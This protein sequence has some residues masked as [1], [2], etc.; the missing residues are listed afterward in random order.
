[1]LQDSDSVQQNVQTGP[2][3]VSDDDSV[4]SINQDEEELDVS[5]P[6][7]GSSDVG[8]QP[9]LW[10]IRLIDI[11]AVRNSTGASG[12]TGGSSSGRAGRSSMGNVMYLEPPSLRRSTTAAAIAT[13][14]RPNSMA[15]TASGLARAF[16]LV[17]RQIADLLTM[18]MDHSALASTLPRNL[19]I[20]Q[21]E[22]AQL[23]TFFEFR[24]KPVWDWL[25]NV[26]DSTEVQLRFG[27]ALSSTSAAS[28][29]QSNHSTFF[30][31]SPLAGTLTATTTRTPGSASATAS[32]LAGSSSA[33]TGSR[34]SRAQTGTS[35]GG[36]GGEGGIGG[37]GDRANDSNDPPTGRREFLNYCLSLMRAHNGEHS[38]TLPV[39]DV[40]SLKHI[41][42]IFDALIYYIRSRNDTNP[43][44]EESESEEFISDIL[45]EQVNELLFY[46][47]KISSNFYSSFLMLSGRK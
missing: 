9:R 1:M 7:R 2:A 3:G 10:A 43:Y 32:A 28:G 5:A 12:S 22:G 18:L 37:T 33:A 6:V 42:Y 25:I 23:Q 39:I 14:P 34:T 24:L 26:M 31:R 20:S 45:N 40:S 38:D 15:T 27:A 8:L 11:N 47:L 29:T 46:F 36:S 16:G 4:D 44:G 13:V 41:A 17:I 21:L 19:E 35:A 30:G